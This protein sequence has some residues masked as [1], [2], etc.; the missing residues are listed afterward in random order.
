MIDWTRVEELKQEV[1][2]DDFSEVVDLFLEEVE[3]TITRLKQ[4]PDLSQL[5][6]DMHFLKGSA[7]NLGFEQFSTLCQA[8]ETAA[9]AGGAETINLPEIFTSYDGSKAEFLK[10]GPGT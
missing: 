8:G 10:G 6:E 3:E 9:A 2:E 4:T 1:G 7:L 5:E